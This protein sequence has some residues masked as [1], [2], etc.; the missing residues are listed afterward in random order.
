VNDYRKLN[1]NTVKDRTP[2]PLPDEILGH[3][4]KAKYWGKIDMTNS[5]FQ[6]KVAKEDIAKTA[7]RTP[8]GLY[9]WVVMPMGLSNAPATHQ[10]RVSEALKDLLGS[11]CH[12]YLDDIIIFSDSLEEHCDRV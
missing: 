1:S 4:A 10:R 11:I 3:C 2:L 6:T 8:W 12:V 9:E 7:V 5:F